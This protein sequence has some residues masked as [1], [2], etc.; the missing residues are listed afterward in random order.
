MPPSHRPIT[1]RPPTPLC[2]IFALA[3]GAGLGLGLGLGTPGI[4]PPAAAATADPASEPSVMAVAKTM[5]AVV[6][7][8]TERV[9]KRTVHDPYD[10]FF[11]NFFG[12]P[13]RPPRTLRQKVQSLGSGFLIDSAGYI[14]TN[15]HVVE[16]A[17]DLKITVTMADGKT[18]AARYITGAPENDLAFIKIDSPTPLPFISPDELSQNLLGQSV[19]VLGNPL[20]YGSSVARGIL[21]AKGRTVAVGETEYKDLIQTDAAINPG[22]SGG[23]LV[24]LAGKLIGV[25]SVKLAFTP[26]GVPTQGLGFA[27]SGEIVRKKLADFRKVASA[28][29]LAKP[30]A[31]SL[32]RK[33]FGLQLQDLTD[34]LR[35]SFGETRSTGVL[36]TDVDPGSPAAESG[37]RQGIVIYQVGRY[38]VSSIKEVEELLEQVAPR[39][40]VDF[41]VGVI[42]NVGGRN[43]R[44]MQ[45]VPLTAR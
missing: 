39:A 40:T 43:Y 6:N 25:S 30:A 14:I 23:P 38:E 20:G 5:P 8:S 35:A 36:V 42:R 32:A 1:S 37:L 4:T 12:G 41:T 34:E 44:Q 33:R 21:S 19:L 13:M 24:D 15:E 7:I 9:I 26:Q 10:E 18:F 17:A 11:N 28:K 16:R 45:A 31:A 3:L 22:N 27:I 29:P 2:R